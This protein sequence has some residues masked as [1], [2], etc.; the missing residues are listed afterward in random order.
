MDQLLG[1]GLG[2]G[3]LIRGLG[4]R[5][6]VGFTSGVTGLDLGRRGWLV[7]SGSC[8]VGRIAR[9]Q[10]I[11]LRVYNGMASGGLARIPKN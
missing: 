10:D 6:K 11:W 5:F 4:F 3:V 8:F 1:L 7:V 9:P 2:C